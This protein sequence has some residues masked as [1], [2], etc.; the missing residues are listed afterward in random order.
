MLFST[1]FSFENSE[2]WTSATLTTIDNRTFSMSSF[3]K[4][5]F[6]FLN[7][8]LGSPMI[9]LLVF[10]ITLKS[11]ANTETNEVEVLK[12]ELES[13]PENLKA[14]HTLAQKYF[15][16]KKYEQT[17][18]VLKTKAEKLPQESL[19]LLAKTYHKLDDQTNELKFLEQL[20]SNYPK[21][22]QGF[23]ML[24]Q[25][26]FKKSLEKSDPRLSANTLAAYKNAIEI[27]SNHRPA[28]DGLL[29]AYE[30]YHNF[31]ELRILLG[32]MLKRFGKSNE[33]LANL[34]RRN[35]I[36]GYFV[37]ARKLCTEAINMD[38]DNPENYIYLSLVE[39]NEGQT[40]KAEA[41]L[42][43]ITTEFPRSEIAA[44]NY[45]DFLIQQKNLPKAATLFLQ[46]TQGDSNSFRAH[47]GLA[48]VNFELK[49]YE[50]ALNAYKNACKV[51][52]HQTLKHLKRAT[53][54][55]RH[56]KENSLETK[57]SQITSKCLPS[58]ELSRSPA[59]LSALK[60]E[61]RSAFA[62]YSK[63]KNIKLG[64]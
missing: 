6:Y 60:E 21:Y 11:L 49:H 8:F 26:Y 39:N 56:R 16:N 30:K 31:Y 22:P 9:M 54:L 48:L 12:I 40:L 53:D 1:K 55:L 47:I 5:Y 15:D 44:S 58:K 62:L 36:D 25:F 28:Y 4:L 3:K 14:R 7:P 52:P 27:N 57:Y 24:G 59:S 37:N 29:A 50:S 2:N 46:A 43:K 23:V 18:D 41:L 13:N 34:C 32:D 38:G 20:T 63:N 10:C 61:F 64:L 42:K 19:A 33:I 17:V 51:N 45:A 35:T